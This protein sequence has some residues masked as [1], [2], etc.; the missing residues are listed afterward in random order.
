[1][2]LMYVENAPAG[3][4]QGGCYNCQNPHQVVIF[5]RTI[6]G[7]GLLVL[8]R[9]CLLNAVRTLPKKKEDGK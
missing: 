1:M 2:A 9:R 8:C 3:T 6:E 4:A 7:E 5:D